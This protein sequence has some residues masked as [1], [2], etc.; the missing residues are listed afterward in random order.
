[1]TGLKNKGVC[2]IRRGV[3]R[4]PG[5]QLAGVLEG[6]GMLDVSRSAVE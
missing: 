2:D 4:R 3:A 5:K 1:M 6:V